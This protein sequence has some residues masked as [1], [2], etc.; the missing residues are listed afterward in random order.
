MRNIRKPKRITLA[1]CGLC[2]IIWTFRVIVG[3]VY[4]EYEYSFGFFILNVLTAFI[5]IAAFVKWML[6]HHS[7]KDES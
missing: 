5:W 7:E 4:K 6:K 3:V 1:L 2:A